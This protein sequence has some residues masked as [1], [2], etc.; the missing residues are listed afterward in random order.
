ML[1]ELTRVNIFIPI[2]RTTIP[3]LNKILTQLAL[4]FG[5]VT[6]SIVS[7]S[8]FT[9][10]WLRTVQ[11]TKGKLRSE[12]LKEKIMWIVVDVDQ[13]IDDPRIDVYFSNLK[14]KYQKGLKQELLWIVMQK[15]WRIY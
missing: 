12:I 2:N 6:H 4:D 1:F 7:P 10:F 3:L 15:S 8:T 13:R 11:D 14:E 9:G 5:G